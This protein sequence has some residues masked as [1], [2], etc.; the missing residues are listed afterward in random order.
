[1]RGQGRG[2]GRGNGQGRGLNCRGG[3]QGRGRG[4]AQGVEGR[5]FDGVEPGPWRRMPNAETDVFRPDMRGM[6]FGRG[7]GVGCRRAEQPA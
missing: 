7:M 3:G 6:R 2:M 5:R 1:M 4:R